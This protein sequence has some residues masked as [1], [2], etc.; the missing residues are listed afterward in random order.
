MN[1]T[2]RIT[3]RERGPRLYTA[4]IN[5]GPEFPCGSSPDEAL[6]CVIRNLWVG[7]DL[8]QWP[9]P[10]LDIRILDQADVEAAKIESDRRERFAT[11]LKNLLNPKG[12]PNA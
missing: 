5:D 12:G 6:G 7:G 8:D 10:R 1:D 3:I 4:V 9:P 11:F 2:I